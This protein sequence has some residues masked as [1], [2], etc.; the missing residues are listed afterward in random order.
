MPDIAGRK[1]RHLD[2]CLGGDVGFRRTTTG[3]ERVALEYRALP[4]TDL[5][6]VDLTTPFLGRTLSAPFLIG[7][8]TGGEEL[9]ARV[10]R[11][12]AEAA[13]A[14]GVG[15]ML[16]SQRIMLER[17]E[18]RPTF[19]VRG[20]APD[21]LLVGNLG[22]VQLL[23]G[24]GGAEAARAVSEVGADALAFHL[25]PLQEAAQ[26]GD[27]AYR[28]LAARLAEV[29]AALPF[30]V[31]VKEVGHGIGTATAALLA[32]TPLAA[33]DVAGAGG[34]SWA[35][36]EELV[37]FGEVRHP[38][39]VE[40]GVP[41]ARA[42]VETRAAL[43][44]VPLVASGGVRTGVDAAKALALGASAVA[45]AR[46]LLAP[47]LE[48]TAAVVAWIDGFLAELRAALFAAGAATPAGIAGRVG[49]LD[50]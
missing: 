18:T 17:P 21:I 39:L 23:R 14:T 2:V 41:T 24:M 35:R 11:T 16:G 46:P 48:G 30:P 27:T 8:M 5:A 29:V 37:R 42:L 7:A 44:G 13:Q 31:L 47:A 15:M 6:D 4:E 38:D 22:A 10:N 25:N 33:V 1:R 50:P 3:F 32:G 28:G 26:G 9:G 45:V 49:P 36:V 12:L 20:V 34:T 19:E 40:L 43:P